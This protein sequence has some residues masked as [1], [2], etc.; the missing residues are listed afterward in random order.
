MQINSF[1][2]MHTH[3]RYPGN[4]FINIFDIEGAAKNGGYSEILAM[5]NSKYIIDNVDA[6]IKAQKIDN[7]LDI[8]V[9]RTG[10]LTKGLLG[11]EP[12]DYKK[13]ISL[14]VTIFTDDGFSIVDDNL[15]EQIF[16][17]IKNENGAVFQHCEKSCHTS[18]GDIAPPNDQGNLKPIHSSEETDILK[19][20]LQLVEQYGTR[21]HAQHLSTAE[22][23]QLVREAKLN[24][25]PV[26]AEVTPHHILVNNSDLETS[27]GMFKMY[28]PIR[29]SKDQIAIID[30]LKD[31][32]VDVI[33]TD[34][35]PHPLINKQKNFKDAARGVV[36]LESSFPMLYSSE[37]FELDELVAFMDE[38][39]R[40]ILSEL[41]YNSNRRRSFEWRFCNKQFYT[42]SEPKNSL[43]EGKQTLIETNGAYV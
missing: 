14:G 7:T 17:S 31:G 27:N 13:F 43:F 32:T 11:K 40:K 30:G 23:V 26:T 16:K 4:S 2:D 19:R 12:T 24:K 37:I 3:T 33:A 42:V 15:A 18:P 8:T 10:S 9:H 41:G 34:H 20:D 29:T 35:A 25:L 28:P 21:Y 39:P 22:S 36:G 38:N 5:P 1:L 6:L